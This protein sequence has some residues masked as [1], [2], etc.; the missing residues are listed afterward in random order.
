M[1]RSVTRLLRSTSGA[2]APTVALSLFGLIAAGGIAF[3]YARMASMDTEL[4][5][6]ADHAALAAA[7]QLDGRTGACDR[8]R[9]A[10]VGMVSNQTLM[11]ND[12][13]GLSVTITQGS[14]C[15]ANS[16]DGVRLYQDINH[17]TAA[18]DDS[19][20]NFVMVVVDSRTANYALTPVVGALSSGAISATAFAGLN[21]AI[22]KVPPVM[23]C[24]PAEST[25]PDFT[26]A[27]YIGKGIRLISNDGGGS[28]GPGNFGFLATNAGNGASVLGQE[29][30]ASTVPGD[31]VQETGVTTDPGNMI[32]VRDA[33]NTRFGIYNSVTNACGSDGSSCPPSAN[34]RQDLVLRGKQN[35]K[36]GNF[37]YGSSISNLGFTTNSGSQPGWEEAT[38]PYPGSAN[39]GKS[40]H[41]LTDTEIAAIAPMGYPEDICHSFSST[42]TGDCSGGL[43]GD[44]TW[45]RYAY[46]KSNSANYTVTSSTFNTFLTSTFGTTTPT[47]YQV[48]QYEM[49]HAST[50]LQPQT[51]DD[52][53][54]LKAFGNPASL[55][56]E[57]TGIT[58]SST[59]GDRR[60]LSV[61]VI[62]C[63]AEGLK[64]KTTDV[65]V[66]KWIDVFLV[67]PSQPRVTGVRT[68]SSDVYV[69]VVG[70]T[71]NATNSGAVQL[72]KKSVPYLIE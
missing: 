7:T 4:Q 67:Q 16:T 57:P 71:D 14:G 10:A 51:V 64:G 9:A 72:I 68:S 1:R 29:L 42:G 58:P 62:N 22:C 41:S 3:D 12:G 46:F 56:G 38:N 33:L 6:A 66:Q 23:L 30:G 18:T 40:D 5:S 20:A 11:A 63:T 47:R 35:G 13:N 25:D 32:S 28:Y 48:Y 2:V 49:S 70:E 36:S 54:G 34:I 15:A 59:N 69:E 39:I 55:S 27:N 43:I 26:V 31:C 44:G 19:N 50:R 21:Q 8:A 45:D 61:A 60:V 52:T 24:N 37:T 53:N 17:T 65:A